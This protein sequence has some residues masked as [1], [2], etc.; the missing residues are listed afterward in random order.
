[1]VFTVSTALFS[2]DAGSEKKK[3]HVA[4]IHSGTVLA[5]EIILDGADVPVI[6]NVDPLEPASRITSDVAYAAITIKADPGRSLSVYDYVL[7][8]RRKD[9][10]KCIGIREGDGDY[11]YQK[12]EYDSTKP[13][14]LYTLLFKVQLPAFNEKLAYSLAYMLN[15]VKAEEVNIPF[16]KPGNS[17]TP[18]SKIPPEG[19][20]GVEPGKAEAVA[21]KPEEDK[22][23][24][25]PAVAADKPVQEAAVKSPGM[26]TAKPE[27]WCTLTMP[28]KTSIG[29][30]FEVKASISERIKEP[31]QVGAN[32]YCRTNGRVS[33]GLY[34][35]APA[36]P[37]K[38]DGDFIFKFD[39]PDK[40]NLESVQV[41]VF[42]SPTGN[43]DDMKASATGPDIQVSGATQ[44]AEAPPPPPQAAVKQETKPEQKGPEK[45]LLVD[46]SVD[47][48]G[49]TF[50]NGQEF[51]GAT[52]KISIDKQERN[53]LKLEGNFSNGGAYVQALHQLKNVDISEIK[54]ELKYPGSTNLCMRVGDT[55]GQC[56]Q[57]NL[58]LKDSSD[59]Q[60]VNFQI[61]AYLADRNSPAAQAV[62]KYE[63]W[64]GAADGKWHGP[65]TFVSILVGALPSKA[66]KITLLWIS[67]FKLVT[68]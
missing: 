19:M 45:D 60:K 53:S 5:A 64:G 62:S 17:F 31:T 21:A 49:W 15:K 7:L 44:K 26:K 40:D 61:G 35:S 25:G 13:D 65:A 37:A 24:D 48:Y 54:A 3:M 59:W 27:K 16:V 68:K 28:D 55:S 29:Q 14:K 56:H 9:E 18:P 33:A 50:D 66:D 1:M 22:K 42:I 34:A 52:G 41:M 51:P 43:I 12:W 23:P 36:Q 58:K 30:A 47:N 57:I 4:R 67:S 10:F 11:D 39:M 63:S 8:N 38:A 2:Q 6:K 32:L 46:K 20:L